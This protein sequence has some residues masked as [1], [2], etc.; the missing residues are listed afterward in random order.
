MA[1]T[2]IIGTGAS[3][4]YSGF[5]YKLLDMN[6]DGIE[7]EFI[8]ASKMSTT[9][10]K[11]FLAATL[12]DPGTVTVEIECDGTFPTNNG[13]Y[14]TL[15]FTF[16]NAAARTVSAAV[17]SFSAANPLEGKVTATVVFQCSGA[18]S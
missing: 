5:T 3:I 14:A 13:T 16:S 18:W 2:A 7:R 8:D 1:V 6:I 9:T 4:T 12:Y 15:T 11:E 10:A 17:K